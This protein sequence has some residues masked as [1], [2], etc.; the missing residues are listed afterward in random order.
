M[1][2]DREDGGFRA[3]DRADESVFVQTDGWEPGEGGPAV[4]TFEAGPDEPDE[5]LHGR[6]ES[7]S[8]PGTVTVVF[9]DQPTPE[10]TISARSGSVSLDADRFLLRLETPVRLYVALD[11]PAT[12]RA[13]SG[14]TGTSLQFDDTGAV[15]LGFVSYAP[16]AEPELVTRPTP[17]GLA[18]AIERL[19]GVTETFN[20]DR[21]WPTQR[22]TPPRLRFEDDAPLPTDPEVPD[23]NLT[24]RLRPSARQLLAAAPLAYY[25]GAGVELVEASPQLLA[26]DRSISLAEPVEV[27]ANDLLTRVFYLD[28]VTRVGGPYGYEKPATVA[29]DTLGLDA[30]RLYDAPMAE[31]VRTYFD[32]EFETVRDQFPPWHLDVHLTPAIEHGRLLASIVA[33]VPRVQLPGAADGGVSPVATTEDGR[34]LVQPESDA[35]LDG[36]LGPG[37][38]ADGFEMV[39]SGYEHGRAALGDPSAV[40]VVAV[41][42]GGAT[43]R[44][45]EQAGQHYET[46][47]SE[48]N[49][50]ASVRTELTTAELARLFESSVGLVHFVG[51]RDERGLQCADGFLDVA[52]VDTVNTESFFLNA[53]GS[54]PEG[55]ALIQKGSVAGGVT[56]ERVLDEDAAAVGVAFARAVVEGY[57]VARALS[58][59]SQPSLSPYDYV[60]VGDGAHIVARE[61]LGPA[62]RRQLTRTGDGFQL[63]TWDGEIRQAGSIVI[64]D[65]EHVDEPPHLSGQRREYQFTRQ[66]LL[67]DLGTWG[68]PILFENRLWW[69]TELKQRLDEE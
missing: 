65:F 54:Y 25:L 3:T 27:P 4:T 7:L 64:S 37:V 13:E 43:R 62:D 28:C 14:A 10:R 18:R 42:N 38:P 31:R 55:Q 36:W 57:S 44:E 20:P 61:V 1:R 56:V 60:V 34:E 66:E 59:A 9:T 23:T 17:T 26:G 24:L 69:P 6:V 47:A 63:V 33:D 21:S 58:V 53:C 68:Y 50:D 29:L 30:D 46:R 67:A 35:R 19:A 48:T 2:I 22:D 32:A 39:P 8:V 5:R 40:S 51:H 11:G 49:L 41:F 52:S 45:H 15:T 16:D 12:I